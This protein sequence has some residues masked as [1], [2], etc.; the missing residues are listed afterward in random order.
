MD[1]L[2][3]IYYNHWAK[4][5]SKARF[6]IMKK[7]GIKTTIHNLFCW[8]N[9]YP[10]E[11]T[12]DFERCQ[13]LFLIEFH[14]HSFYIYSLKQKMECLDRIVDYLLWPCQKV[15]M[16]YRRDDGFL[17]RTKKRVSKNLGLKHKEHL[18]FGCTYS[19]LLSVD[20]IVAL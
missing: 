3:T 19:N 8:L 9:M 4:E 12:I 17:H 14:F 15:D 1:T 7:K 16:K 10:V 2:W 18:T 5:A 20:A 11:K 13:K 6:R